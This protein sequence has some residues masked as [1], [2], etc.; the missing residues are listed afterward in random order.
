M[1]YV[2]LELV[3]NTTYQTFALTDRKK[4]KSAQ[5]NWNVIVALGSSAPG[6][7]VPPPGVGMKR[8]PKAVES[9]A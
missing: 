7:N 4:Q 1:N 3:I 8:E 5:V 9:F 6:P 2:S